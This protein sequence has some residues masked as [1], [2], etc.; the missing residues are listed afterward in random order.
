MKET[1]AAQIRG[2]YDP[3]QYVLIVLDSK[4]LCE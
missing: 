3:Q 1:A 2:V 4:T